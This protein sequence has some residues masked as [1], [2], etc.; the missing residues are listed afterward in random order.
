MHHLKLRLFTGLFTL[1]SITTGQTQILRIPFQLTPHN[2]IAISTILNE[3]DTVSLMFHT[4]A[5]DVTLTEDA[6]KK[7]KSLRFSGTTDGIKSWGGAENTARYS[8]RNS[9]RIGGRAP[10]PARPPSG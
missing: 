7:L 4:A 6:T 8:A 3:T 9:L 5:S 1:A 2:N 10:A